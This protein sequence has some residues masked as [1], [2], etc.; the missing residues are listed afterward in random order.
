[1]RLSARPSRFGFTAMVHPP[2]RHN[3]RRIASRTKSP[4]V[5]DGGTNESAPICERKLQRLQSY[6]VCAFILF[7]GI[8]FWGKRRYHLCVC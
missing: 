6:V 1:M 4:W 5:N 3:R 7:H 2:Q 8:M